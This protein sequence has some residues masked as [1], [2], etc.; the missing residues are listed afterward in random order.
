MSTRPRVVFD[1]EGRCNACTWSEYERPTRSTSSILEQMKARLDLEQGLL[2]KRVIQSIR[3]TEHTDL[4]SL[5]VGKKQRVQLEEI[6][7]TWV[8]QEE[9]YYE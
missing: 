4:A 5:G 2:S 7:A 9:K 6:W 3:I 1:S 8:R